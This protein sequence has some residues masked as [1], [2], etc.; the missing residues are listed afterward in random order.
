MIK[1]ELASNKL[2]SRFQ[3]FQARYK[4]WKECYA[5]LV[6]TP[7]TKRQRIGIL[8]ANAVA[9]IPVVCADLILQLLRI[10]LGSIPLGNGL[11]IPWL[12]PIL[13]VAVMLFGFPV[14]YGLLALEAIWESNPERIRAR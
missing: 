8:I 10:D 7:A 14:H 12:D 6:K 11:K 13:C 2:S 1:Q 5:F 4:G 3:A 9:I